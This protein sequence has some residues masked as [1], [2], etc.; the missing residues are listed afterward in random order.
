[1]NAVRLIRQGESLVV[2]E[3]PVPLPGPGEVLVRL[4]ACGVCHSDLHIRSGDELVDSGTLPL[5]LGHEGVGLIEE[6]GSGVTGLSVG[7]RVGVPWLHDTCL[8]CRDCL[9][10]HE[11]VCVKQ[12]A[13]GMQVD[14]AFA[15]YVVVKEG[16][17]VG[18]PDELDP[19]AAAP[20]LCAGVTAYGAIKRAQLE[21]GLTCVIL[22][23]GGLGQ[24]GIQFAR[25]T[26]ARVIAVD[27]D[28]SRLDVARRLGANE[29]YM[30]NDSTAR[31]INMGGGADAFV[32]FAPTSEIWGIV[33][34]SLR[35]RGRFVSVAMPT[36]R[37]AMSL[38]WL[39]NVTP[40][41]TGSSVGGR[42]DLSDMLTLAA[43]NGINIPVERIELSDVDRALDRLAGHPNEEAV[44]GRLVV[45]FSM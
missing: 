5:T 11:S 16:F 29:C 26:G 15:E 25:L 24:Y 45:D 7:D 9:S 4:E 32:N 21:P 1:M 6:T 20:L 17:T 28:Q 12:R 38:S 41:I 40:V 22:G 33:E 39:T 37:V 27:N 43:K 13:H 34:S 2:E 18:I 42:L 30:S 36:E 35:N 10:G 44:E 19:I 14:G 31:K 3:V 8:R 23:C